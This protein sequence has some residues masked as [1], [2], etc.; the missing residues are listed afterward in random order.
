[1]HTPWGASQQVVN[2]ERGVNLVSTAGH[3]GF[4]VARAA[5]EKLLSEQARAHATERYGDYFAFEEDCDYAIVL[6]EHPEYAEKLGGPIHSNVYEILSRWNPKYLIDKGEQ[7][8]QKEYEAWLD[9]QEERRLRAEKSPELIVAAYGDWAELV[10]KGQ[11]GIQAANDQRYLV[12]N[13]AY[14]ARGYRL[15]AYP[16]KQ[17]VA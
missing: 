16:E 7:P 13:E 11:V 14:P 4:M 5:A 2:L 8:V 6:H 12:P 3:G 17:E 10:P 15:S 9:D 1:M